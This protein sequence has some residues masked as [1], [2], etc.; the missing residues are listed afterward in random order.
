METTMTTTG[1]RETALSRYGR[2]VSGSTGAADA[3]ALR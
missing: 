1:E 2:A 3:A